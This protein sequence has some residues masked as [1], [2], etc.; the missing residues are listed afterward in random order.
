MPAA[1]EGVSGGEDERRRDR[2]Q[3]DQVPHGHAKEGVGK[4]YG[5]QKKGQ[6]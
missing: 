5:R 1:I 6:Q 3:W 2:Q 4:H